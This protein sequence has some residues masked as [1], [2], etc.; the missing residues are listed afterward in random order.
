MSSD[1]SEGIV[2]ILVAILFIAIIGAIGSTIIQTTDNPQIIEQ[3]EKLTE[4]SLNTIVLIVVLFGAIGG[5]SLFGLLLS[6]RN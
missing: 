3:T 4:T 6:K 5:L 1:P 2:I